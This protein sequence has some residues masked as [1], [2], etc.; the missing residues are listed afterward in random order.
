MR[1][2][3]I[4]QAKH[5]RVMVRLRAN[6]APAKANVKTRFVTRRHAVYSAFFS[7]PFAL[8]RSSC[9]LC[10]YIITISAIPSSLHERNDLG[11][12][13]AHRLDNR[14]QT[15]PTPYT[16]DLDSQE[17]KPFRTGRR[18]SCITPLKKR[19]RGRAA[20]TERLGEPPGVAA[21]QTALH[22]VAP[23]SAAQENGDRRK[24]VAAEGYESG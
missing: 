23:S 2:V 14:T 24:D 21:S 11:A 18:S 9:A 16:L 5:G 3:C 10:A 1:S 15:R 17:S 12:Q 8:L 6:Q 20:N 22:P 4:A 19:P 7:C 13:A